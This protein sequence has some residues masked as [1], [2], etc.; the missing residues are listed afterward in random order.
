VAVFRQYW[1][2]SLILFV[3]GFL[4]SGVNNLAHAGG[5]LGGYLAGLALGHEE[6]RAEGGALRVAALGAVAL[7]VLAFA[8]AIRT[9]LAP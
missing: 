2:W 3:M 9:A 1:Q 6:G 5:F 8:L 4:M 7:T